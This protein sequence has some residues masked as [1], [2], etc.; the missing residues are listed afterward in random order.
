LHAF[1][2]I[3]R[4]FYLFR[5]GL[6]LWTLSTV[7][8]PHLPLRH[9]PFVT[10]LNLLDETGRDLLHPH[11]HTWTLTLLVVFHAFLPVDAQNLPHVFDLEDITDVKL[12]QCH[13]KGDVDVGRRLFPLLTSVATAETEVAED[14]VESAVSTALSLLL[15]VL[16]QTLLPVTIVDLLLVFVGQDL[17]GV[18]D[19][20]EPFGGTLF[21]VFVGMVFERFRTVRF[22][23]FLRGRI[24][25]DA[26]EF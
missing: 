12:F 14:V 24:A 23:D 2:D 4:Q 3:N 16:F 8:T 18:R 7:R 25:F 6:P 5:L 11:L 21:L 9:A 20:G 15:L 13:A 22:L 1:L 17:V 26:E 10:L 19:L